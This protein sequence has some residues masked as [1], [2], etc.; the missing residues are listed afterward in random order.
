MTPNGDKCDVAPLTSPFVGSTFEPSSATQTPFATVATRNPYR[1][2]K[3]PS[4]ESRITATGALR[5]GGLQPVTVENYE[6]TLSPALIGYYERNGYCWVVSGSTQ[7]G[8][9]FADPKAVPLAIAL[10]STSLPLLFSR[11]DAASRIS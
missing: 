3:Y 6:R 5:A 8:R 11:H 1:W 9:A 10:K 2:K 4:L 7:S